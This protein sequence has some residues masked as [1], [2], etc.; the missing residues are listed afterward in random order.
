MQKNIPIPSGIYEEVCR[1]IRNKLNA[2]VYEPS[3]SSYFSRWFCVAKKDG[4]SLR[5]IHSLEPLNKVTQ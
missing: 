2:G 3:N 1:I 4:K 5:I